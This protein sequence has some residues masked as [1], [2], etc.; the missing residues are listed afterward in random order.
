M[1]RE[2][3]NEHDRRA[4][5]L[6]KSGMIIGSIVVDNSQLELSSI[7]FPIGVSRS[8]RGIEKSTRNGSHRE[9]L[10][11]FSPDRWILLLNRTY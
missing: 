10:Y 2:P 8:I 4:V 11:G 6:L 5:C 3:E 1:Q 7:A 9:N